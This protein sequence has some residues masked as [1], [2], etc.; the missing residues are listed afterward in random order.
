MLTAAAFDQ[1]W[2]L[3]CFFPAAFS[4]ML[5]SSVE[6]L[7]GGCWPNLAR[8]AGA[9]THMV[10]RQGGK[11]RGYMYVHV[12]EEGE[13]SGRASMVRVREKREGSDLPM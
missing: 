2:S 7:S 9:N 6:F 3:D 10:K 4:P 11:N 13:M 8:L 5:L 1:K 12:T